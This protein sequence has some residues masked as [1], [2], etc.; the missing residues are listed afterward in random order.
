MRYRGVRLLTASV[1]GGTLAGLMAAIIAPLLGFG[2]SFNAFFLSLIVG[3]MSGV[4]FWFT[5]FW[6]SGYEVQEVD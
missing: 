1:S 3:A 5:A 6:K 2:F 4:V